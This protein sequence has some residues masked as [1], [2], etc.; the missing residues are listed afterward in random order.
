MSVCFFRHTRPVKAWATSL[1]FSSG[2]LWLL[3]AAGSKV[4]ATWRATIRL[5]FHGPLRVG[6]CSS[7]WR[8]LRPT[9]STLAST[10]FW[11]LCACKC[12]THPAGSGC[13][14]DGS[15]NHRAH[16]APPPPSPLRLLLSDPQAPLSEEIFGHCGL[17]ECHCEGVE[18]DVCHSHLP[19]PNHGSPNFMIRHLW[20]EDLV[21][22]DG[23]APLVGLPLSWGRQERQERKGEWTNWPAWP[24]V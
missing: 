24:R 6:Y 23:G 8:Q 19:W 14:V 4:H 11:C 13:E 5:L 12:A 3:V 22:S 20:C 16:A 18:G 10:G 7:P 17:P 9:V 1:L 15:E 21:W 2:D